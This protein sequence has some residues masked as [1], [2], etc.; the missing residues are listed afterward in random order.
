MPAGDT[1][2]LAVVSTDLFRAAATARRLEALGF[3]CVTARPGPEGLRLEPGTRP[4]VVV[5]V[6]TPG[7]WQTARMLV[8]RDLDPGTAGISAA[9]LTCPPVVVLSEGGSSA[10]RVEALAA[11]GSRVWD[12]LDLSTEDRELAVRLS[13]LAH[14]GRL[15]AD[16]EEMSRRSAALE[17]V[18]RLTGLPVHSV[19]HDHL[20]REFRRAERYE[21]PLTLL[22][23]DVDRLRSFNETAGHSAGDGLLQGIARVLKASVRTVDMAARYSGGQFALLLPET[24][25]AEGLAVAERA[26]AQVEQIGRVTVSVGLATFPGEGTATRGTLLATAE[27]ALR[28]AKD[29]GRNRVSHKPAPRAEGA[30]RRAAEETSGWSG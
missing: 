12:W 3:S 25:A 8:E 1:I 24:P 9:G 29:E 5:A 4:D 22:L 13:R 15:I 20:A 6:E 2:R 28:R 23:V 17:T 10:E 30:Q 14:V 26:R 18:D 11:P 21:R 27:S 19:F 16:C 7:A